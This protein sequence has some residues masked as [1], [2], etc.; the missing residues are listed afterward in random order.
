MLE[1]LGNSATKIIL[2]KLFQRSAG[3]DT[4]LQGCAVFL[5]NIVGWIRKLIF[6]FREIRN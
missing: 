3:V 2:S 6:L 1:L 5:N 4:F